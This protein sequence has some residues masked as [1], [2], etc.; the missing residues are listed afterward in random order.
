MISKELL[1]KSNLACKYKTCKQHEGH[2]LSLFQ[3]HFQNLEPFFQPHVPQHE[4]SKTSVEKIVYGA[5][6][7]F[8][9]RISYQKS[10]EKLTRME[11]NVLWKF[12]SAKNFRLKPNLW[13]NW[14]SCSVV[15]HKIAWEHIK[16]R[17]KNSERRQ[18]F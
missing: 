15:L 13:K 12:F 14:F 10:D 8:F 4:V 3:P 11:L 5:F 18:V 6:F 16:F 7:K 2:K 9:F 17:V 1:F